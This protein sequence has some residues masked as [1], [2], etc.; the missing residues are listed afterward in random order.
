MGD[1]AMICVKGT[2]EERMVVMTCRNRAKVN[3]AGQ[4]RAFRAEVRPLVDASASH[5]WAIAGVE[6]KLQP[7]TPISNYQDARGVQA[8]FLAFNI[9]CSK[10][11]PLSHAD[12]DAAVV[13]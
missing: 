2:T 1:L 8:L 5:V 7:P 10:L 12:D 11:K 3:E 4:R 13:A 6:C 9:K